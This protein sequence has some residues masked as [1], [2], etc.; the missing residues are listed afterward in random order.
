MAPF[1][2]DLLLFGRAI[3]FD[4]DWGSSYDVWPF[5]MISSASEASDDDSD[6]GG[7]GCLSS[8]HF[9][10]RWVEVGGLALGG[11]DLRLLEAGGSGGGVATIL[12]L[13]RLPLQSF[14]FVF[15]GGFDEGLPLVVWP[16]PFLEKSK[17]SQLREDPVSWRYALSSL[18]DLNFFPSG[19]FWK[20]LHIW[21][22]I[23]FGN[24]VVPEDIDI[25]MACGFTSL[26]LNDF[27]DPACREVWVIVQGLSDVRRH[28]KTIKKRWLR[29]DY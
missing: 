13:W 21:E 16:L 29:R 4:S 12:V 2:K 26:T 27:P 8:R 28:S 24:W 11:D 18:L 1:V 5:L 7:E 19:L 3:M 17:S 25:P 15:L 22:K 14:L 6:L 10:G 23:T 9:F 20:R